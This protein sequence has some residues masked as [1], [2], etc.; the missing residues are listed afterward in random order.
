MTFARSLNAV[1]AL[2]VAMVLTRLLEI[3]AYGQYKKLWLVFAVTGPVIVASLVNTL[4]YRG[5]AGNNIRSVFWTAFILAGFYSLIAGGV[6]YFGAEK[7]ADLFNAPDLAGVYRNFAL[8]MVIATF[9]GI[10]EPLFIIKKRH[11]WLLYYNVSYNIVEAAM[12]ITPF[13]IGFPLKHVV[14]V[15]TIGPTL[16]SVFLF[17]FLFKEGGRFPGWSAIWQEMP[18][19][20]KYGLGIM[21][22]SFVGMAVS[23]VDKWVIGRF[24]ESDYIFAVYAVGARR[25][26]FIA[27]LTNSVSSSLVLQY[28]AEMKRGNYS[29]FL[30]SVKNITNRLFLVIVPLLVIL[31]VFSEEL[32][33]LVFQKYEASAPIFRIYLFNI[34]ATL[35]FPH[36]MILSMGMS[37]IQARIGS[38][39]L[40]F[41]IVLSILLV[42]WIGLYGPAIATLMGHL[43]YVGANMHYCKTHYHTRYRDFLPSRSVGYAIM[44]MPLFGYL[45]YY[46]KIA[47]SLWWSIPLSAILLA[48]LYFYLFQHFSSL[49]GKPLLD[50]IRS[51]R[52]KERQAKHYPD[53]Y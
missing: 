32:M 1:F 37:Q 15:M 17:W 33:I 9:A 39:E 28:S 23:E 53:E 20:L 38:M 31:F 52:E 48:L 12:I 8:W 43:F 4:Y 35:L 47:L 46:G 13:A 27:A 42:Q 40:V 29:N 45:C 14:L 41:N 18:V 24:F 21:A 44:L 10:G 16:R 6:G 34:M 25:I 11:K 51:N 30:F 36:S 7:W 49:M 3:D 50:T 19:S 22:T 5:G 26:P 2:I